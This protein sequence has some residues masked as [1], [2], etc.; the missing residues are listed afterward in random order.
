VVL[1]HKFIGNGLSK[2][3]LDEVKLRKSFDVVG[4]IAVVRI[5]RDLH[6]KR[7]TI[8]EAIMAINGS[9][10]TVLN[11]VSPVSGELRLRKLEWIGGEKKTVTVYKEYGCSFRV[12]LT[13][14]YFSP[15]LSYERQRIVELVEGSEVIVNM[16][17]GVGCFSIQI[18]KHRK[19]EKV[20]SI[21]LNPTAFM[22][23]TGNIA[24]NKVDEQVVAMKGDARD[25]ITTELRGVAHRVLM[26]LPEKAYAYL[27][28]AIVALRSDG[29]FVHY[30]DFIYSR[31]RHDAVQLIVHKVKEKLTAFGQKYELTNSR[32][33]R[34]VGPHKYQIVLDLNIL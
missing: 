10:R 33:V 24:L 21:D 27:D 31:S 28:A 30:Y 23:M 29:G 2:I 19:V 20:Y 15:R 14:V 22:F 1:I 32:I 12:D 34:S 9:V 13:E 3:S 26:P 11:Q 25:V 4:D 16:F 8:A 18:A 5:P 7:F 17:A 6:E